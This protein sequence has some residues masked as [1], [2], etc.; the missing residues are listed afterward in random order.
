MTFNLVG[1]LYFLWWLAS[2]ADGIG[3]LLAALRLREIMR[4]RDVS[5]RAA[6][7][8]RGYE[9]FL[10]CLAVEA[11]LTLAALYFFSADY[12]FPAPYVISRLIG[13]TIKAVGVWYY[14]LYIL[15]IRQGKPDD[16]APPPPVIAPPSAEI[17]VKDLRGE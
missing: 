6:R 9:F 3:A 10:Y 17:P 4:R 1:F 8:A 7:V 14:V 11:F 12:L 13:R 15:G 16:P 5:M 2:G